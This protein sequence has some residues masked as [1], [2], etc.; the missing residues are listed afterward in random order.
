MVIVEFKR[1]TVPP[2]ASP[3]AGSPSRTTLTGALVPLCWKRPRAMLPPARLAK[4]LTTPKA[5]IE[6]ALND[7]KVA[8]AAPGAA[9]F[10]YATVCTA[11][12]R[13][14]PRGVT[15]LPEILAVNAT[16]PASLK[17]ESTNLG[18]TEL[19]PKVP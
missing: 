3:V 14:K 6:T 10:A 15:A 18:S 7:E 19:V 12:N 8:G 9:W 4:K 2:P 17:A 13:N 5:F 16:A 11:G 1:L